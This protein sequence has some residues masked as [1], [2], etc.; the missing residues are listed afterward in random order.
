MKILLLGKNGQV[1]RELQR[2]LTPIGPVVALDR[3]AADLEQPQTLV[4]AIEA[5]CPDV[6]VNAA[7]YTAVDQ[8][9]EDMER[10]Y[11]VNTKAV[12]VLAGEAARRDIWLV[13]YSSDYVFDGRKTE[14]YV[15]DDGT[16]PLSVYGRSKLAGEQAIRASG[17]RHLILRTSWVYASQ[18]RN[19][20]KTILQ[21]ARERDELR[22]V[23]DQIGAPTGAE[24][25]AGVTAFILARVHHEARSN[26]NIGTYHL[27]AMGQPSWHDFAQVVLAEAVNLGAELRA[28]PQHVAAVRTNAY[29][30]RAHRPANSR[31]ATD[32]LRNTFRVSL[33]DWREGVT[34]VVREILAPE[35]L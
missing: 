21:L 2:S 8:A 25:V 17:A 30:T 6:I 19:F 22:V 35:L 12:D 23:A 24:L 15:E 31:L 32:K 33:P 14:P 1:G 3:G 5:V 18:G 4:D 9:E 10:A 28:R 11:A 7:A 26:E 16:N 27:T 13:H 34:R 29:P 20:I